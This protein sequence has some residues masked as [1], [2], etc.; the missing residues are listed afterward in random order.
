MDS[1]LQYEN[2]SV[3]G[4]GSVDETGRGSGQYHCINV[5]LMDG[6]TDEMYTYIFKR[7]LS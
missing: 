3:I 6:I 5:P 1:L 7:Y 4:T 2:E